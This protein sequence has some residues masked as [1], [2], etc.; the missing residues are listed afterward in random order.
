MAATVDIDAIL[1]EIPGDSPAGQSL[2][3]DDADLSMLFYQIRDARR[4]ASDAE[5]AARMYEML[6]D[7]EREYE[8]RPEPP[9][10]EGVVEYATSILSEHSKDLWVAAWLTEALTRTAGFAGL[11][12]GFE[13]IYGLSDRYWDSV[14]P[15]PDEQDGLGLTFTQ[16]NALNELLVE[17]ID[18]VPLT[19]SFGNHDPLTS[20]NYKDAASVDGRPEEK[21]KRQAEGGITLETFERAAAEMG[22]DYFQQLLADI[23]AAEKQI[24][25]TDELIV[26]KFDEVESPVE[27]PSF[28]R[29]L[30][31]LAD[32]RHRV[33]SF[34]KLQLQSTGGEELAPPDEA[35][36]ATGGAGVSG[37]SATVPG[38]IQTRAEAFRALEKIADFFRTTEPHS[39]VSYALEQVVRW[40]GMSLPDLLR[41]LINDD[42]VRG[43]LFRRTGIGD[44]SQED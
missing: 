27:P 36:E 26:A 19:G 22:G 1:R 16:I 17:V 18:T 14:H 9:N 15:R 23:D 29:I 33:Q 10:W 37:V 30:A 31:A 12:D 42:S 6:D 7:E 32:C 35:G 40:G 28:S 41:E 3:G 25:E 24:G 2:R 38:S 44:G 13:V 39:P 20:L 4:S 5:R 8:E 34:A 11:R 43:D 21:T